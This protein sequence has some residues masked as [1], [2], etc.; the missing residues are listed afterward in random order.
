MNHVNPIL[1]LPSEAADMLG[2]HSNTIRNWANQGII[3]AYITPTGQRRFELDAI[4]QL[5]TQMKQQGD[6]S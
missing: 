2:V 5:R 6:K 1:I 4:S 3:H